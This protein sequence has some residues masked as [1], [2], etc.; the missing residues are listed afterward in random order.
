M[1]LPAITDGFIFRIDVTIPADY[2]GE[3]PPEFVL[4]IEA[5]EGERRESLQV[6][7]LAA[8]EPFAIAI[9]QW[10]DDHGVVMAGRLHC[11]YVKDGL[12]LPEDGE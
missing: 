8:V 3:A 2:T 10:C 5:R 6:R 12:P 1:M 11:I 9:E 7:A 4:V